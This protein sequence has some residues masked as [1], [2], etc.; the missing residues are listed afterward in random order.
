MDKDDLVKRI[1]L[2]LIN[3][4]I[5]ELPNLR[6]VEAKKVTRE[7]LREEAIRLPDRESHKI[8]FHYRLTLKLEDQI[9]KYSAIVHPDLRINRLHSALEKFR[10][11]KK[12][13]NPLVI[14]LELPKARQKEFIK[15]GISFIDGLGNIFLKYNEPY[16]RIINC[17]KQQNKHL[18]FHVFHDTLFSDKASLVIRSLLEN[19]Q[20]QFDDDS[21]NMDQRAKNLQKKLKQDFRDQYAM[22]RDEASIVPRILWNKDAQLSISKVVKL[23]G[24]SKA[25]VAQIINILKQKNALQGYGEHER[26]KEYRLLS[27]QS[28]LRDWIDYYSHVNVEH[29]VYRG[30]ITDFRKKLGEFNAAGA[31]VYSSFD[32]K[33]ELNDAVYHFVMK[34][35]LNFTFM[36]SYFNLKDNGLGDCIII[37]KPAYKNSFSYGS[38]PVSIPERN[39]KVYV[40]SRLQCLLDLSQIVPDATE[41]INK[42]VQEIAHGLEWKLY[43]DHGGIIG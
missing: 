43:P 42:M 40:L 2:E 26:G 25:V 7:Q 10:K 3:L 23:S 18:N 28:L 27:A 29:K 9:L 12:Y 24:L 13:Q 32:L 6:I 14:T 20:I 22:Y 37:S 17:F 8:P 11:S 36:E 5:T 30:D 33:P 31:K 21:Q 34:P 38:Y 35:E 19:N 41:H 15:K 39:H 1:N 16:I 4:S